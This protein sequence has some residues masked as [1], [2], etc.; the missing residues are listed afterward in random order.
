MS[1]LKI[2]GLINYCAGHSIIF[3]KLLK[4]GISMRYWYRYI[5]NRMI[6]SLN[7]NR[8]YNQQ[9]LQRVKFCHI[10]VRGGLKD[11]IAQVNILLSKQKH[12]YTEI[13][14]FLKTHL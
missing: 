3:S 5:S 11:K 2:I 4:A 8:G 6:H 14:V 1:F 9:H 13:S 7:G 12:M 10:N